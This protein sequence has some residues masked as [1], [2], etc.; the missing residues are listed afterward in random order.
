MSYRIEFRWMPGGIIG[1]LWTDSVFPPF[2]QRA[3]AEL[4]VANMIAR[5]GYS[6]GDLRIKEI[7][8]PESEYLAE[9]DGNV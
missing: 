6:F 5:G 4:T 1:E 3:K 2:D 8:S 9:K 7:P